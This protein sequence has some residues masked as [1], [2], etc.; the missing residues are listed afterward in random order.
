MGPFLGSALIAARLDNQ[1]LFLYGA[2]P[3]FFSSVLAFGID[4]LQ[5]PAKDG[6]GSFAF[7]MKAA[8]SSR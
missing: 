4:R 1:H 5:S 2:V 7:E 8:E 3:V 6:T